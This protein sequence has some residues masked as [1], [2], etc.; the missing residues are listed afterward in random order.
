[1]QEQNQFQGHPHF[2][3]SQKKAMRTRVVKKNIMDE[4]TR[5][6]KEYLGS[7]LFQTLQ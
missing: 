7:E 2:A 3:R 1:M 6:E 4:Q 5:D